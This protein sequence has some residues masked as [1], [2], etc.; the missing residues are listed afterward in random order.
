[1]NLWS[2]SSV[3]GMDLGNKH[4]FVFNFPTFLIVGILKRVQGY[5][6]QENHIKTLH[7]PIYNSDVTVNFM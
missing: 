4:L 1:M 3:L 2:E 6:E 5:D 7:D